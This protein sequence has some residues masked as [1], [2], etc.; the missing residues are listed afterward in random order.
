MFF[1]LNPSATHSPIFQVIYGNEEIDLDFDR[2]ALPVTR[3]ERACNVAKDPMAAADFFEF[4]HVCLFRDLLGWNFD[5]GK[6]TEQGGVLGPLRSHCGVVELTERG[7]FHGHYLL[8]LLGASNPSEIR[9][10]LKSSEDYCNRFFNF[11]EG[12]IHHHLP[13][14]NVAFDATYEPRVE[15]PPHVPPEDISD[16]ELKAT[17]QTVWDHNFT[18]QH[19]VIG[20]KHQQHHCRPVCYKGCKHSQE[21]RFGFPHELIERSHF[22]SDTN[23]VIFARREPDVNG[24]N[25]HLLV[26]T[27]HNHDLKCILSGKAAK[28][29]MFYISDYITKMP[30]TTEEMLS[31]LSRAV[32]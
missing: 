24:H 21:C 19:R 7:N 14:I 32:V 16:P 28:A 1:T 9:K 11:F 15:L 26:S 13:D 17:L 2:P 4:M 30:M 10:F 31:L 22:K 3:S 5:K 23:S 20:E 12:I 6:S 18:T 27:R 8:W 29:A 25:P